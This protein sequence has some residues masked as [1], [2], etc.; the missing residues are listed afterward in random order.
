METIVLKYKHVDA[1]SEAHSYTW[2]IIAVVVVAL[3]IPILWI[4]VAVAALC[5]LPIQYFEDKKQQENFND[6]IPALVIDDY[7]LTYRS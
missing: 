5:V 4:L 6:N 2:L 1:S 7:I 3:I